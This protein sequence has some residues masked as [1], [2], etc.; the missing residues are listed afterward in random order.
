MKRE[1]IENLAIQ[2]ATEGFTEEHQII[3]DNWILSAVKD[4]KLAFA[5]MVDMCA[6][7]SIASVVQQFR[8]GFVKMG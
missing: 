1:E 8:N 4:D 6:D 2:F 3:Y 5:T 7:V